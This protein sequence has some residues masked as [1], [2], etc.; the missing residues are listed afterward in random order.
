[1]RAARAN[2]RDLP[3]LTPAAWKGS[4]RVRGERDD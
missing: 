4:E 2:A 3:R 1:V